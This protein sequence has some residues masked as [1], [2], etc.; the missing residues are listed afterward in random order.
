M[1]WD[2]GFRAPYI[3]RWSNH[4][5]VEQP[6]F[7]TSF[8]VSPVERAAC[9]FRTLIKPRKQAGSMF[10][11]Y[12][13]FSHKWKIRRFHW[14]SSAYKEINIVNISLY[15]YRV[16]GT[17]VW[18]ENVLTM[19]DLLWLETRLIP[20]PDHPHPSLPPS[21]GKGY[22]WL[23]WWVSFQTERG[24]RSATWPNLQLQY[25]LQPPTRDS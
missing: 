12:T 19:S 5:S 16:G 6:G 10:Y 11:Y 3:V 4:S 7:H 18:W 15:I 24:I 14:F 21:R 25:A 17:K 23:I 8:S 2:K 1:S 22:W 20:S 13:V 9:S